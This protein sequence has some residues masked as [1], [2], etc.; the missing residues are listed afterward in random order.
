MQA[1]KVK[2]SNVRQRACVTLPSILLGPLSSDNT[3]THGC[4][5][6][7]WK[8]T[9]EEIISRLIPHKADL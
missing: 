5:S 3:L 2:V 7:S 8:Q 9:R 1:F 4:G 6:E